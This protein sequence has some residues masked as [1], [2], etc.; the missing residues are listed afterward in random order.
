MRHRNRHGFTLIELLVTLA[1]MAVLAT[2]AVPVAQG[3][4]QR[5]R[6]QDLRRA[7]VDIRRALDA[8]KKASDEGRIA[9]AIN[10]NGYPATLDVLVG[11]A[12]DQR[13]PARRKLFFLRRIPRDP[14]QADATLD[15]AASWG[16]RSYASEAAD[17]QEGADVYD[18]VSTSPKTG[19]N[20]VPYRLW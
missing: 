15:A 12:A 18:V 13:D 3:S 19:L 7:L 8:Y 20:G 4:L 5:A 1:I 16:K 6:E 17:P 14:M 11:G 10:S 2:L 9:K